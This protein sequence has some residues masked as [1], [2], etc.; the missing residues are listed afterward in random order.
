MGHVYKISNSVDDRVYIGSTVNLNRRW[1]EH[2][3]DLS[4]NRH[5]NAHLQNFVNK[6]GLNSLIFEILDECDNSN[7]LTREQYYLDNYL[8]KFNIA[9]NSSA[10]MLNK[11]HTAE[12]LLK[13]SN[14]STGCNNGMYGKKRP[15]WLIDKLTEASLGREKTLIEKII[16]QINLPNRKEIILTNNAE[17]IYCFSIS[18]ASTIVGVSPQSISKALN[19]SY[20][21]KGW[22]VSLS[23][24]EFYNKEVLFSNLNLFNENCHPQTELIQM[25]KS[26]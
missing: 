15:Q 24:D 6:Y 14:S 9:L 16:R 18:H 2:R 11:K 1:L 12:A 13:I 10:P 20:K 23:T 19:K 21:S 26:L 4:N 7:L 8:N 22:D 25:L 5:G 17:S 3:R